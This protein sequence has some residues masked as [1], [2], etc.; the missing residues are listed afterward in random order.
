MKFCY[1]KIH[2]LP[3]TNKSRPN[4]THTLIIV[5]LIETMAHWLES[6]PLRMDAL[7]IY[8]ASHGEFAHIDASVRRYVWNEKCNTFKSEYSLNKIDAIILAIVASLCTTLRCHYR[9]HNTRKPHMHIIIL[10]FSISPPIE[11]IFHICAFDDG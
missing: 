1:S 7:T 9:T 10:G 6:T 5:L 4:G 2:E 8:T 11:S 3:T